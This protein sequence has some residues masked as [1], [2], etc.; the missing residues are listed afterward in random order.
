ME[1]FCK[2]RRSHSCPLKSNYLNTSCKE[3]FNTL[4]RDRTSWTW[5]H[6][7]RGC[8]WQLLLRNYSPDDDNESS[9]SN[10]QSILRRPR[11][12]YLRIT[13]E[14]FDRKVYIWK[15]IEEICG[16]Y[17]NPCEVTGVGW[18]YHFINDNKNIKTQGRCTNLLFFDFP[19]NF[20]TKSLV[21]STMSV[22]QWRDWRFS[23]SCF[24]ITQ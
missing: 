14:V 23:T 17:W 22:W 15:L 11:E 9:T 8:H 18:S 1:N 5:D 24:N 19:N 12:G 3:T 16:R 21:G 2:V 20:S 10:L 7:Q 4:R 6:L 13:G